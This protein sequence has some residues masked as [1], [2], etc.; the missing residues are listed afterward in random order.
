MTIQANHY[1]KT[2]KALKAD[3]I[4]IG[5]VEGVS[6]VPM[7]QLQHEDGTPRHNLMMRALDEYHR[8]N[9]KIDTHIG[10]PAE[11]ILELLKEKNATVQNSNLQ[12]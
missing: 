1:G 3:P 11:A 4:I 9:G 2:V 12:Q 6:N 10:G 5:M 8:Q 7:D